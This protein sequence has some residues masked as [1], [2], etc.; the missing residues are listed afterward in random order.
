MLASLTMLLSSVARL[1][2]PF[3]GIGLALLMI[4]CGPDG[5]GEPRASPTGEEGEQTPATAP[6]QIT[7]APSLAP[8]SRGD[9][10]TAFARAADATAA[11]LALPDANKPLVGRTFSLKLPFG[12]SGEAKAERPEW[13]SWTFDRNRQALRL[14]ATPERWTDADWVKTIAEGMAYE[15][16]EGFW[17]NRPWTSS[18]NCPAGNSA[19]FADLPVSNERQAVGIAQFFAPDAPRTFQRGGRPYSHTIRVS[20]PGEIEGR[21]YQL[22]VNGRVKA[23]PD[24]QPIRCVQDS[25]DRRPVCL[26]AVELARVSFE[27]ARDGST[28]IEWRN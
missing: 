8:V 26:I 27:D 19:S 18:E 3:A 13:A 15:I 10:L 28:L 17:I 23:F 9:L 16:V 22:A 20:D 5:S 11:G 7:E 1:T 12:C 6:V 14:T 4:G 24:G 25:A 21:T 2:G